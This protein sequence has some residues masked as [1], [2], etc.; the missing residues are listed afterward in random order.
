MHSLNGVPLI[1]CLLMKR[2]RKTPCNIPKVLMQT[3]K[4]HNVPEK[5]K[6]SVASI[7]KKMKRWKHVLNDD[8]DNRKF[9]KKHFPDFLETFDGFSYP[10]QR[11]DAIRYMWLYVHGGLYLDL[12]IQIMRDL[13]PLFND[14]EEQA[15]YFVQS[16]DSNVFSKTITNAFMA[17]SPKNPFWLSVMEEM[18][19]PVPWWVRAEYH[20]YILYSTG[21]L[22]VN[23]VL[24]RLRPHHIILP[25]DVFPYSVCTKK[26]TSYT[27][28]TQP[29]EGNSW[30]CGYWSAFSVCYCNAVITILIIVL[31]VLLVVG[32]GVE[33]FTRKKLK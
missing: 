1:F 15:L 8:E 33:Y 22:M 17:S 16:P 13:T 30:V 9:V 28:W 23:R 32:L 5:W 19:K 27:A 14:S 25:E 12:D 26:F 3:W 7:R 20:Y 31:V 11:A 18:K 29:L 21:P 10:I 4:T 2:M 6:P 24:Q